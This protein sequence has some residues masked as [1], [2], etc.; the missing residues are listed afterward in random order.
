MVQAA[1]LRSGFVEVDDESYSLLEDHHHLHP[2]RFPAI[3]LNVEVHSDPN[4]PVRAPKPP[5]LAEILEAAVPSA[6]AVEGVSAP[7]RLH[8]T[9]ILA[10]HAWRHESLHRLRDLLDIAVLA[11]GIPTSEL[12]QTAQRWGIGRLWHTTWNAVEAVFYDGRE[13]VALRLL[14]PHLT[15]ARERTVFENHLRRWLY[16]YWELPAHRAL[17]QTA[18]TVREELTPGA[19]ETW[20]EKLSRIVSALRHPN[21]S[22]ADRE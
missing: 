4:W 18:R 15:S 16:L 6:L 10:A 21:R 8:H 7:N 22:T 5:P 20:Q 14:A 12:A 3:W 9:L 17:A 2:I 11:E 13:T 19:D 1:L